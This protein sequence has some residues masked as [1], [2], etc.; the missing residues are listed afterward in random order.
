MFRATLMLSAAESQTCITN[1]TQQCIKLSLYIVVT[2]IRSPLSYAFL[3]W[4]QFYCSVLKY[5]W[6]CWKSF[7]ITSLPILSLWL[8]ESKEFIRLGICRARKQLSRQILAPGWVVFSASDL[9]SRSSTTQNRKPQ[10]A[11]RQVGDIKSQMSAWFK[12]GERRPLP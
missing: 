2:P 8:Y 1:A 5:S 7:F 12:D 9:P 4:V 3:T 11:N 10:K 6:V